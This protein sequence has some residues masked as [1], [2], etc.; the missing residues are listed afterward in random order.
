MFPCVFPLV[1]ITSPSFC[2][3]Y[4]TTLPDPQVGP[5]QVPCNPPPHVTAPGSYG[6]TSPRIP[7]CFTGFCGSSRLYTQPWRYGTMI[8]MLWVS[9]IGPVKMTMLSEVIYRFSVIPIKKKSLTLFTKIENP[10]LSPCIKINS[11]GIEG[12][13]VKPGTWKLPEEKNAV[14]YKTQVQQRV[15]WAE[16]CSL[17]IKARTW[18]MGTQ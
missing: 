5:L 14:P 6:A 12:L 7:F 8:P 9:R 17:W 1:I 18:Q 3:L 15:L 10:Y 13:S 4:I 11:K 2:S 16:F